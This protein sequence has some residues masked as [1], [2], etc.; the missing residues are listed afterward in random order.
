MSYG[1][2]FVLI[3][4][5]AFLLKKDL[6][7]S[8][9]DRKHL[10]IGWGI[11]LAFGSLYIAIFSYY[12]SDGIIFGDSRSFLNDGAELATYAESQPLNYLK[13]LFG[14]GADNHAFIAN[15]LPNTQIWSYGDN[16]DF[17]NDNRL[18]IRVNSVIHF[19]SRGNIWIHA[20]CFAAISY[21]GSLLLFKTFKEFTKNKL[22]SFYGLLCFP[23]I[24]FWGGGITKETILLFGLGVFFYNLKFLMNSSFKFKNLL[25]LILGIGLLLF[26]K[27]HVGIFILVLSPIVIYLL[28]YQITRIKSVI[29]ILGVVGG[30]VALSYTPDRVNIVNRLSYK[31]KDLQNLGNGGVFFIN[32]TAFCA[33]DYELENRFDY[34]KENSIISI[35]ESAEGEYKLFGESKFHNFKAPASEELFDVYRVI[36]PSKS[37]VSATPI[38][39]SGWQLIKNTPMALVNVFLR[40]SPA[41]PG[42]PLKFISFL[43]NLIFLTFIIF[44]IFKRRTLNETEK[45]WVFYLLI[46]VGVIALIIGWSTPILGAIVRYKMASH[47]LLFIALSIIL[48]PLKNETESTIE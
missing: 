17:I 4:I 47:L 35:L 23:T 3:L 38:N 5:F 7:K 36:E 45:S 30:F 11:K 2:A 16:G 19:I 24:S 26:N 41:D 9:L 42:D 25:G 1:I 29:L 34:D 31:Q 33:F 22:L 40:P 14:I 37:L 6:M 12:F 21:L 39:N 48:K 27:P 18:I 8:G 13:L 43:E 10:Y 32:D 46:S 20:I 44:V 28:K 15:E